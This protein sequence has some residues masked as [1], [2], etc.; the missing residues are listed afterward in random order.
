MKGITKRIAGISMLTI[1]GNL[2]FWALSFAMGIFGAII[3]LLV[4]AALASII[5][6]SL[7][8]MER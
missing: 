7:D 5:L 1:V 4:S 2:L 3:M 6:V 8:L